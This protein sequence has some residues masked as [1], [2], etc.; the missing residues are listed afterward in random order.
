M[1]LPAT[2]EA[3]SIAYPLLVLF[4]A[5]VQFLLKLFS[6]IGKSTTWLFLAGLD[7]LSVI[8]TKRSEVPT[9]IILLTLLGIPLC[10]LIIDDSYFSQELLLMSSLAALTPCT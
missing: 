4:F 8:N 1:T 3:N 2:T 10:L 9:L 5:Y 7:T 6:T